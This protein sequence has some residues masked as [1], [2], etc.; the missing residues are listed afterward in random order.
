MLS[1]RIQLLGRRFERFDQSSAL[2]GPEPAVD[3]ERAVVFPVP[4][5]IAALMRGVGDVEIRRRR[6]PQ[7]PD[8]LLELRRGD[9]P[10]RSTSADSSASTGTRDRARS[11]E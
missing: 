5:D 6:A 11:F 1:E 2:I 3:P 9:L 7:R 10:A 8:R 4:V